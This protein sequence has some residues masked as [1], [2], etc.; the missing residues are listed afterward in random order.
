MA[1][2]FKLEPLLKHKKRLEDL[3]ALLLTQMA[4]FYQSCVGQTFDILLEKPGRY[5][6]QLI[7]RSPYLQSVNVTA[8]GARI[9]DIVRVKVIEAR[10]NSLMS[11]L[12]DSAEPAQ[13]AVR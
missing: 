6:G 5:E 11:E 3:Q 8:P 9:G 7:G 1:K 2:R 13:M 4:A 12:A 10:P